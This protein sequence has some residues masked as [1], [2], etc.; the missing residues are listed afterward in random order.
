MD[1]WRYTRTLPSK[2]TS[3]GKLETICIEL[4]LRYRLPI[5]VGRFPRL[6]IPLLLTSND[7]QTPWMHRWAPWPSLLGKRCFDVCSTILS[8]EVSTEHCFRTFENLTVFCKSFAWGFDIYITS[9]KR[10]RTNCT[11]PTFSIH[12]E[13]CMYINARQ[14]ALMGGAKSN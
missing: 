3:M 2:S 8:M 4:T 6:Y 11:W 14:F 13:R 10:K 12:L 5:F 7:T 9:P 1:W